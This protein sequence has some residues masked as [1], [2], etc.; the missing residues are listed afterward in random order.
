MATMIKSFKVTS[1]TITTVKV[2]AKGMPTDDSTYKIRFSYYKS[3]NPSSKKTAATIR[4]QASTLNY[5]FTDLL[6]D[7]Q[8]TFTAE[9]LRKRNDDP[10]YV[11]ETKSVTGTTKDIP[12]DFFV[13]GKTASAV[14]T[15]ATGLPDFSFPTRVTF[16][17]KRPTDASYKNRNTIDFDE[18]STEGVEMHGIFTALAQDTDYSFRL[19]IYK[20]DEENN[21][22]LMKNQYITD[23]TSAYVPRQAPHPVIVSGFAV[24]NGHYGVV[25]WSCF[26]PDENYTTHIYQS[27][28]GGETYTDLGEAE[29][30]VFKIQVALPSTNYIKVS[31]VDRN[32]VEHNPSEPYEIVNAPKTSMRI[33]QEGEP[34]DI[35]A[36]RM[37]KMVD[38][39]FRAYEY[40]DLL[41][42]LD[43]E[44]ISNYQ[45]V[46]ALRTD[47]AEG[48]PVY[49]GN[50][51]I[52][53]KL[54]DLADA[55]DGTER[56]E[57]VMG[58]SGDPIEAS[59]FTTLERRVLE[60]LLF[61]DG[62]EDYHN[63]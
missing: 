61:E 19:R 36:E 16:A 17:Y 31:A 25:Q 49:G 51:G 53:Q 27:T 26:D 55:L 13:S 57:N 9:F 21:L 62:Y 23:R 60:E 5:T 43:Q 24:P 14:S 50:A 22:T 41:Y 4:V 35:P 28:D 3:G 58:D 20:R 15:T 45:A 40:C 47:L 37:A 11:A 42:D 10:N 46:R 44:E 33:Y 63:G 2:E 29:D 30:N 12:L 34:F 6:A 59:M 1:K 54:L 7:T 18:N 38:M 48:L 56:T 52:S 32:D 39:V 8:Y